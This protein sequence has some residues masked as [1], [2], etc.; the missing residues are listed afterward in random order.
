MESILSISTRGNLI[1]GIG[2]KGDERAEKPTR[3][4]KGKATQRLANTRKLPALPG[5]RNQRK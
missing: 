2:K 1:L 3:R 5:W 4:Q